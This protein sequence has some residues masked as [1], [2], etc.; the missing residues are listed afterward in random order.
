MRNLICVLLWLVTCL[1]VVGCGEGDGSLRFVSGPGTI[2]HFL[3][4]GGGY[5]LVDSSGNSYLP[6]NLT[7]E[8]QIDGLRVTFSGQ[9]TGVATSQQVGPAIHLNTIQKAP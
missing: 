5:K 8:F 6:D 3:I 9:L 7:S 2:R 1:V 4:E